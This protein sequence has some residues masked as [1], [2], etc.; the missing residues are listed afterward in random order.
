MTEIMYITNGGLIGKHNIYYSDW[1]CKIN[2]VA[3]ED[4]ITSVGGLSDL[5][6][7]M[8]QYRLEHP[9]IFEDA[10]V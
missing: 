8:E 4:Q 10:V 1:S 7:V 6:Y 2:S 9:E 5:S 3:T